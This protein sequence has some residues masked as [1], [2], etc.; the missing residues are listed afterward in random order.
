MEGLM[1]SLGNI[2]GTSQNVIIEDQMV[3]DP[4]GEQ[5]EMRREI[6]ELERQGKI[7]RSGT[8]RFAKDADGKLQLID[9]AEWK[10]RQEVKILEELEKELY[11][12][13]TL[14]E[15]L[16]RPKKAST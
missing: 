6:E 13:P 14:W 12:E 8:Y 9:E 5:E 16:W 3:H 2:L 10:R 11:R 1:A 7:V 15:K 4:F